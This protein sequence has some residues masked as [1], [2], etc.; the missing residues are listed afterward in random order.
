MTPAPAKL[1]PHLPHQVLRP[2]VTYVARVKPRKHHAKA[3]NINN[4]LYNI[5]A[6]GTFVNFYDNDM[7]PHPRFLKATVPFFF[8]SPPAA[9]GEETAAA[10][11]QQHRDDGDSKQSPEVRLFVFRSALP[12]L[13]ASLPPSR[14]RPPRRPRPSPPPGTRPTTSG[15]SRR[16]STSRRRTASGR[17]ATR[18]ATRMRRFT[19]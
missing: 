3:G 1:T 13:T 9:P 6:T 15:G 2:A 5:G 12:P 4:L 18:S 8:H 10:A 16:R 14:P 19:R 17:W 11:A 7:R